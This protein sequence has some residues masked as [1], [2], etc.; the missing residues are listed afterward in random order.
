MGGIASVLVPLV[1]KGGPC[2][3]GCSVYPV[4]SPLY[5][6]ELG[7]HGASL[8]LFFVL[9]H[10]GLQSPVVLQGLLPTLHRHVEAREYA[11]E[12]VGHSLVGNRLLM[13]G[14]ILQS[15]LTQKHVQHTYYVPVS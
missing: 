6:V 13:S 12:P 14:C 5:L 11:A 8:L 2:G 10:L 4:T 7:Q 3:N 15:L 1:L 9:L